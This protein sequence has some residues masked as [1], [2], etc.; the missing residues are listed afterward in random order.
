MVPAKILEKSHNTS[1]QA[2]TYSVTPVGELKAPFQPTLSPKSPSELLSTH[3]N[4]H[5]DPLRIKF[6]G[7][8]SLVKILAHDHASSDPEQTML[9][10]ELATVQNSNSQART[11][12]RA[13]FKKNGKGAF[14]FVV[15]KNVNANIELIKYA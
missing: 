5:H 10:H 1:N 12:S 7:M 9:S 8:K 13:G 3:R 14:Y 11:L 4:S 2:K 6:S 15:F